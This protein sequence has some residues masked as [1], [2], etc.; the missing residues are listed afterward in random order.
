MP[1]DDDAAIERH[2]QVLEWAEEIQGGERQ[3]AMKPESERKLRQLRK[4]YE[5]SNELTFTHKLFVALIQS[6][7]NKKTENMEK[8]PLVEWD[9]DGLMEAWDVLFQRNSIPAISTP[10]EA[11]ARVLAKYPRIKN[12]KPDITFGLQEKEF[13]KDLMTINRLF[14]AQAGICP[15]ELW[16][17]FLVVEAKM[18]GVIEEAEYQCVRGGAALVNA[19]RLLRYLAGA[20]LRKPG[21]DLDTPVFS[22]AVIPSQIVLHV[23]WAE[24]DTAGETWFHMHHVNTYS[25]KLPKEGIRLHHDLDN[26]LDWGTQIRKKEVIATLTEINTAVQ[27]GTVKELSNLPGLEVAVGEVGSVGNEVDKAVTND[28][29]DDD[30]EAA[31]MQLLRDIGVQD[32]RK[33][34]RID[35]RSL[36]LS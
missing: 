20:D 28:V 18:K 30:E 11:T 34:R 17:P 25:V 12:P 19:A 4:Q 36:S 35:S 31:S 22:L 2:P 6:K 1:I 15:A 14:F 5:K 8:W 32:A 29:E 24:V 27:R 21:P 10:D 9:Q 26:I 13:S 33:R 3:S 7:R 16:H 23:H